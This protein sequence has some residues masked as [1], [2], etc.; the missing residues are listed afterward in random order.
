VY[1]VVVFQQRM[2]CFIFYSHLLSIFDKGLCIIYFLWKQ[3]KQ[4]M[5]HVF[6]IQQV[7]V[8]LLR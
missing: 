8:Q 6:N 4:I 7:R 5:V 3:E 2:T 1:S